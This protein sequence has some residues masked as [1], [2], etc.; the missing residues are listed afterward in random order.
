[1]ILTFSSPP[2]VLDSVHLSVFDGLDRVLSL[3]NFLNIVHFSNLIISFVIGVSFRDRF[4][5]V[6]T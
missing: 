3:L 2:D 6:M 1:M 4:I 5:E